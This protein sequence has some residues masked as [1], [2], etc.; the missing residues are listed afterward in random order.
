MARLNR[1]Y[2]WRKAVDGIQQRGKSDA[3]NIQNF[4]L[5]QNPQS[6]A[7]KGMF[8][9][10]VLIGRR[11]DGAAASLPH[12]EQAE[13]QRLGES[14]RKQDVKVLSRITTRLG[15]C[16]EDGL[17]LRMDIEQ[18][19]GHCVGRTQFCQTVLNDPAN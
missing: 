19:I 13:G 9:R 18:R 8:R 10:H 1:E 11:I 17:E 3:D 7:H 5:C 6:S 12:Q 14:R 4:R 16:V 15:M 2:L